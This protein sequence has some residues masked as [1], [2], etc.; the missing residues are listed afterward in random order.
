AGRGPRIRQILQSLFLGLAVIKIG[1]VES[2]AGM[3]PGWF[4]L[5]DK[6]RPTLMIFD[7]VKLGGWLFSTPGRYEGIRHSANPRNLACARFGPLRQGQGYAAALVPV[8]S[9]EAWPSIGAQGIAEGVNV[10]SRANL[11][12]DL[13]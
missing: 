9:G 11:R 3:V 7:G 10:G 2:W 1:P 4:G 5:A 6:A 13:C 8:R 12:S